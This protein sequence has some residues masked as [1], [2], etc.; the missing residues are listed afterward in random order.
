[1]SKRSQA[2]IEFI[3]TYGFAFMVIL[4]TIAGLGYFG[5]L[6]PQNFG[7]DRC[8]MTPPFTCSN[9]IAGQ[10]GFL[11][12]VRNN[13]PNAFFI[14]NVTYETTN[15]VGHCTNTDWFNVS[16]NSNRVP[17]EEVINIPCNWTDGTAHRIVN[18]NIAYQQVGGDGFTR[19]VAGDLL[20]RRLESSN[21]LP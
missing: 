18:Y 9:A 3:S 4:A 12:R 2:A 16:L 19:Y 15:G 1:M 8:F 14:L 11:L 10:D 7:A 6:N 21:V 13:L 17:G 5:V 20:V